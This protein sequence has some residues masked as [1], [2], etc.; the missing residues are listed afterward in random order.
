MTEANH[1][2]EMAR[3]IGALPQLLTSMELAGQPFKTT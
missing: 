3:L 1:S 2:L